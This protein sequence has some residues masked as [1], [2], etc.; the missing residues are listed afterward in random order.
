MPRVCVMPRVAGL[1]PGSV[2]FDLCVLEDGQPVLERVF[3]SGSLADDPGPL[4]DV[5]LQY[6]PYDLIYGP[7]GYGVPLIA[8]AD[9]DELC[10]AQMVLVRPD[11]RGAGVGI[12]GMRTLMR[13]LARSGLPVVFGPGVI[14]LPSV[15]RHRKYNR[16]DL[17]T[18]D[19]VCSVAYAI[20]DQASW[21]GIGCDETSFVL[22]ELGGAF[23][24]VVAVASGRIID[25]AGGSS[26][27]IGI[28]ASGALDGEL[29][30]LLGPSLSKHTLFTG[31]ALGPV[32]ATD[33][34]TL[35]DESAYAEGWTALLDAAAKA[36]RGLAGNV[37]ELREIVVTGRLARID[38]PM[39]WLAAA[40]AD[41]APVR[42]L[43]AGTTSTAAHGGA[44]LADGLAGGR[45]AA[46]VAALGLRE[47]TGTVLDHLRVAGADTI[48]LG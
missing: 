8:A 30:Y 27:P 45:H 32:D 14:H 34:A 4:L 22:V 6:G 1:D 44:L 38:G 5:L 33:L 39:A 17:G 13:E 19:K 10:L 20:V 36:A 15:P 28:R 42:A 9:V 12:A 48:R 21:M 16:I 31:G 7:S 11:E 3:G 37:P 2:S 26:G 18:A 46:V 47:A 41:V 25:G 29:A 35:W 23:T 43:M 24:A 40:L